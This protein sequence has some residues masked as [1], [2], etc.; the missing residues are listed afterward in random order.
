MADRDYSN[1]TPKIDPVTFLQKEVGPFSLIGDHGSWWSILCWDKDWRADQSARFASFFEAHH[2]MITEYRAWFDAQPRPV[3][4]F[5]GTVLRAGAP[6]KIGHSRNVEGRLR[7][8]QTAHAERL[9][10]FATTP[11]GKAEEERYH[12][13]WHARRRSG[14]WFTLG[15]CI[16]KEIERLS[17]ENTARGSARAVAL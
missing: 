6:V 12:R 7:T 13:R 5:I 16:I 14:E 8:L 10:I 3:V 4:Y 11:G 1:L 9:Q 15:D 17:A 2:A